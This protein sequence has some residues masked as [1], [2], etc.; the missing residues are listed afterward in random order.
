MTG[1][2]EQFNQL[3]DRQ[4]NSLSRREKGVYLEGL[5]KNQY[6]WTPKK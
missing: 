5:Y 6:T 2:K 3:R 1:S 4:M